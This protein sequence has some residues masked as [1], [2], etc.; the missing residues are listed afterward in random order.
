MEEMLALE[1]NS[2]ACSKL[3]AQCQSS[4]DG[5]A[6]LSLSRTMHRQMEHLAWKEYNRRRSELTHT[7]RERERWRV[8]MRVEIFGEEGWHSGIVSSRKHDR[9]D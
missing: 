6:L 4:S 2:E 1:Q 8:G 3:A 7:E 5:P 9:L